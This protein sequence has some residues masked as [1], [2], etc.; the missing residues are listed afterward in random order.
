MSEAMFEMVQQAVEDAAVAA[1]AAQSE[2]VRWGETTELCREHHRRQVQ[3]AVAVALAAIEETDLREHAG[4]C[5]RYH[6]IYEDD[7]CDCETTPL[8]RRVGDGPRG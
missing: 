2:G 6:V 4:S 1:F 3:P 5:D 7:G 8:F